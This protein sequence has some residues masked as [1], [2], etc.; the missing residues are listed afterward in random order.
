MTGDN[1]ST[2]REHLWVL[3]NMT[4]AALLFDVRKRLRFMNTA[5]EILFSL[6]SRAATG[7]QARDLIQCPDN[8]V[9][10]VLDRALATGQPLPSEK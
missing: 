9:D 8:E 1:K 4:T 3:D 5:S 7:M 6:S 10:T 2:Q